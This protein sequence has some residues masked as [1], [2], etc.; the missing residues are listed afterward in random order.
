MTRSEIINRNLA[1]LLRDFG[2]RHEGSLLI[3][4][5][6]FGF[7]SDSIV[8]RFKTTMAAAEWLIPIIHDNEFYDRLN[9]IRAA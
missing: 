1:I 8:G 3:S 5:G 6:I 2:Y 7:C 9:K 4:A